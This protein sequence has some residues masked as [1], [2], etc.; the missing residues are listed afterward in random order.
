MASRS[1]STFP[2]G[3]VA[4]LQN[5][6][7]RLVQDAFGMRSQT[8]VATLPIDIFDTGEQL[9]IQAFVPGLRAEHLDIQVEDSVVTI[10]GQYPHLYDTEEARNHTWYARELRGGRFQRSVAGL[11]AD[12]PA[13]RLA[14]IVIDWRIEPR[15][16]ARDNHALGMALIDILCFLAAIENDPARIH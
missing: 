4:Y 2:F 15:R 7:D 3:D 8:N 13:Q 12:P 5:Q 14:I 10:S 16:F 6:L 9:V 11:R 1:V